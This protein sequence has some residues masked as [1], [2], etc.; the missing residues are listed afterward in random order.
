MI[1][2]RNHVLAQYNCLFEEKKKHLYGIHSNYHFTRYFDFVKTFRTTEYS[3]DLKLKFILYSTT[4]LILFTYSIY[5][6]ILVS[7]IKRKII[8]SKFQSPPEMEA[9]KSL[10]FKTTKSN[11]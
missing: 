11:F 3:I 5:L 7:K 1:M 8:T 4:R 6:F 10:F 2:T 9:G